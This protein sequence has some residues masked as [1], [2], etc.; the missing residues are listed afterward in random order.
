MV[1]LSVHAHSR[2]RKPSPQNLEGGTKSIC[3]L[4]DSAA[5][6]K[7]PEQRKGKVES[8]RET[9]VEVSKKKAADELRQEK[10]K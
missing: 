6:N 4:L 2:I 1:S 10:G 5:W 7:M 8:D 3:T 9:N